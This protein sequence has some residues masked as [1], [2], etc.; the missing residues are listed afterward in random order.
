MKGLSKM[1]WKGLAYRWATVALLPAMSVVSSEAG[2]L[3]VVCTA[4]VLT[5][6][7]CRSRYED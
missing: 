3:L 7:A 4:A 1:I 2:K 5:G 6:G